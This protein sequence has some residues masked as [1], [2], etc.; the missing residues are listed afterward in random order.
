MAV[1]ATKWPQKFWDDR[2]PLVGD[3]QSWIDRFDPEHQGQRLSERIVG[4]LLAKRDGALFATTSSE[5]MKRT[6]TRVVFVERGRGWPGRNGEQLRSGSKKPGRLPPPVRP[7]IAATRASGP[8]MNDD[9]WRRS[10]VRHLPA[11]QGLSQEA[12]GVDA[13]E[14]RTRAGG[15]DHRIA[16][17]RQPC[18]VNTGSALS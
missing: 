15:L 7:D 3:C 14:R 1:L 4:E 5:R 2:S 18:P 6:L 12:S 13:R 8:P 10:T 16:L 11:K 9:C 17:G